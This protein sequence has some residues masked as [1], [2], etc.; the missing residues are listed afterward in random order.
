MTKVI[1]IQKNGYYSPVPIMPRKFKSGDIV[2]DQTNEWE[3][4]SERTVRYYTG[5]SGEWWF[6]SEEGDI[7]R[8]W[9]ESNF[10]LKE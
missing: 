5:I 3:Y 10:K 9:R 6:I 8:P 4:L 7:K 1:P 2:V